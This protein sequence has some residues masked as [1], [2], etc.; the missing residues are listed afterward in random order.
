MLQYL[1]TK[2]IYCVYLCYYHRKHICVE[3][4]IHIELPLSEFEQQH[5]GDDLADGNRWEG[6]SVRYTV[7]I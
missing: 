5:Y 7:Y 1:V 4:Y 3:Y 6:C 2:D